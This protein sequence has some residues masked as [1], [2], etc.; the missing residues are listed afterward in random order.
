MGG[1]EDRTG[2]RLVEAV[3]G[4]QTTGGRRELGSDGR[5]GGGCGRGRGQ[6]RDVCRTAALT[7]A[8]VLAGLVTLGTHGTVDGRPGRLQRITAR[9]FLNTSLYCIYCNILYLYIYIC[10]FFN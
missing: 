2:G 8:A 5:P 1:G 9:S 7:P 10:I 6:R 4:K 3:L